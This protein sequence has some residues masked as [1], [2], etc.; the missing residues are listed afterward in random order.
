MSP[1]GTE[2]LQFGNSFGILLGAPS[3]DHDIRTL[4]GA[5][6]QEPEAN[7]AVGTGSESHLA[8]QIEKSTC[9]KSISLA[10]GA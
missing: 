1:P 4:L 8:G 2:L 10:V 3:P 7:A 9:H 5:S 6:L